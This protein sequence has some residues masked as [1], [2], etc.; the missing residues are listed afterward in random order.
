MSGELENQL[1]GSSR[2]YVA[3]I[4]IIADFGH[5]SSSYEWCLPTNFDILATNST[6]K[7][8]PR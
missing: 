6:N 3:D 4:D 7:V 2:L 5:S 1:Q 8:S